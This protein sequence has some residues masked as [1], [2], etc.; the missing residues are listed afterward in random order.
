MYEGTHG[1]F[2]SLAAGGILLRQGV[3]LDMGLATD[4]PAEL[5]K[6]GLCAALLDLGDHSIWSLDRRAN[7][8]LEM[9]REEA[10]MAEGKIWTNISSKHVHRISGRCADSAGS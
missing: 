3:T 9:V 10:P 2:T 6:N 7:V 8:P 1:Y 5:S 4:F